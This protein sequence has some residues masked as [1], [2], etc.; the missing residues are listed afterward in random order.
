MGL[1]K[2]IKKAKGKI[3]SLRGDGNALKSKF[4]IGRSF[5]NKFDQFIIS[6]LITFI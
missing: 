1:L 3:E 6:S 5:S 2:K 4:G